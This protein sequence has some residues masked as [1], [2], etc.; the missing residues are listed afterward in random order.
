MAPSL[1]ASQLLPRQAMPSIDLSAMGN[2][3]ATHT[4]AFYASTIPFAVI[5]VFFYIARMYSRLRPVNKLHWDDLF[6]TLGV[7]GL[8][9]C[10]RAR[11][12]RCRSRRLV[13]TLHLSTASC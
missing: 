8:S 12:N 5:M 10:S 4:P 7:V 1:M 2:P 6:L 13:F 3:K 9:I 11:A